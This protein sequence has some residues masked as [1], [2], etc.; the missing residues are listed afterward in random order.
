MIDTSD[1]F[2]PPPPPN[3]YQSQASNQPL[4]AFPWDDEMLMSEAR[5]TL[6]DQIRASTAAKDQHAERVRRMRSYYELSDPDR[7]PAWDNG[8]NYMVP[9]IR[10]KLDAI[11]PLITDALWRDPVFTLDVYKPELQDARIATESFLDQICDH[12]DVRGFIP[13]AVLEASLTPMAIGKIGV[14]ADDDGDVLITLDNVRFEDFLINPVTVTRLE[15]AYF[16]A[17][18]FHQ[19][20]WRLEEMHALGAIRDCE[21]VLNNA[22]D[23][24]ATEYHDREAHASSG[25]W[26]ATGVSKGARYVELFECWWRWKRWNFTDAQ[27]VPREGNLWHVWFH[28]PSQTI[29]LAE[30]TPHWVNRPPYAIAHLQERTNS[31]FGFSLAEILESS[32]LEINATTN[33]RLDAQALGIGG[34]FYVE[35]G[36]KGGKYFSEVGP[37]PGLRVPVENAQ[38][39]PVMPMQLPGANP[40]TIQDINTI[41]QFADWATVAD[42][43]LGQ[44]F[45]HNITATEVNQKNAQMQIKTKLWLESFRAGLEDLGWLLLQ[46]GLQYM[47]APAGLEGVVVNARDGDQVA[48]RNQDMRLE[49]FDLKVNGSDVRTARV[50]SAQ[51]VQL[52]MQQLGP[53]LVPGQPSMGPNGQPVPGE[54][55]IRQLPF[56]MMAK[57]LLDAFDIQDWAKIIGPEPPSPEQLAAMQQQHEQLSKVADQIMQAQNGGGPPAQGQP[58]PQ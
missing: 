3:P 29:L 57:K 37:R 1:P 34:M 6:G 15:D 53:F 28:L 9:L 45:S 47:V 48:L 46:F 36:T 22:S 8:A 26:G 39:P 23:G 44:S 50:E 42:A 51:I 11:T 20:Y 12:C 13:Q 10:G 35:E 33:M 30:P 24:P 55:L 43:L 19:P 41:R 25:S 40:S 58:P 54:P 18:R 5:A 52:I 7:T 17:D 56:W 38:K 4:E 14:Q 27:G 16:V 32:Q 49:E 21:P 31:I 2:N